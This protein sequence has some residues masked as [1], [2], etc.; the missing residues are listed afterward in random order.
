M[1]THFPTFSRLERVSSVS[2]HT[3]LHSSFRLHAYLRK[4]NAI[5]AKRRKVLCGMHLQGCQQE[6]CLTAVKVAN[7]L[8]HDMVLR[9]WVL[10]VMQ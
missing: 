10:Q 4:P 9:C 8:L 5:R 6:R 1:L 3:F 2:E 7:Q